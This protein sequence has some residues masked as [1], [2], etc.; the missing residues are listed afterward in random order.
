MIPINGHIIANFSGIHVCDEHKIEIT[1]T[2]TE[3]K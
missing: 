3:D 2:A 1:N